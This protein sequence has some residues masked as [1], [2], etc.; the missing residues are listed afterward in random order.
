MSN[1]EKLEH[2]GEI[3]CREQANR[4]RDILGYILKILCF[5]SMIMLFSLSIQL[6]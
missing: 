6:L 3:A 1:E 4:A 2:L 5:I